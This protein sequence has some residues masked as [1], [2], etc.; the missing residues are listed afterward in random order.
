MRKSAIYMMYHFLRNRTD[1]RTGR[2]R[3]VDRPEMDLADCQN[4]PTRFGLYR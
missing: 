3:V 4:G 1:E 2:I